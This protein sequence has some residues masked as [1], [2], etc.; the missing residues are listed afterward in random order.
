M[1]QELWSAI[2]Q[3]D[4]DSP[5]GDDSFSEY[6]FSIRLAHENQWPKNFTRQAILEYKKFMYLAA[7]ASQMVSPSPIVDV[8]WHQ[9]LLFTQ[10]YNDFCSLLGRQ[11]AHVPSTHNHAEANTFKIAKERTTKLYQQVFGDQPKAIWEYTTITDSLRLPTAKFS[12]YQFLNI[13]IP[14][15]LFLTIPMTY[16]L[17]PV[18]IHLNNPGFLE[19]LVGI[20]LTAFLTLAIVNRVALQNILNG[21]ERDAYVFDLEPLELVF[22]KTRKISRVVSGVVNELLHREAIR[23]NPDHT[24]EL[25]LGGRGNDN[26]E[27]QVL[28]VIGNLKRSWYPAVMKE[29]SA[30]PVFANTANSMDALIFHVKKSHRYGNLFKWNFV[31]LTAIWLIAT[32]RLFNGM[33]NDRP[34]TKIAA[35]AFLMVPA[36]GF[37]LWWLLRQFFAQTIP[38]HYSKLYRMGSFA[39]NDWQWQYLMLGTAVLMPRM[40]G[41]VERT[42]R[43]SGSTSSCGTSCGSSD[44]GGGDGGGSS[45]GSSC[46]GCGGGGD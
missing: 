10:S 30:K 27:Q 44:G 12:V 42:D 19:G 14:V 18:L 17:A 8:V 25:D 22:L 21:I 2:L 40:V 7:T 32:S 31:I 20:T 46:G 45:C 33:L 26:E 4:L 15:V 13:G 36:I 16:L 28:Q 38:A 6:S 3:F 9:H 39:H 23:V 41:L 24:L 29:L 37:F 43:Y 34:V 5:P 1:Q 35:V 11:I